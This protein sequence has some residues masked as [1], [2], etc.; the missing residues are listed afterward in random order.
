MDTLEIRKTLVPISYKIIDD[1]KHYL[2]WK[3]AYILY[4]K[5]LY[6][7]AVNVSNNQYKVKFINDISEESFYRFVYDHSSKFISPYL[8][9]YVE[10]E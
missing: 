7:I 10:M 9:K 1:S 5:K 8:D 3:E 2:K 6:D 4:L